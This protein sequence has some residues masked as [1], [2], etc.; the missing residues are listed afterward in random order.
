MRI[1]S[2]LLIIWL[3]IAAIA[4]GQRHYYSGSNPNCAQAGTTALTVLAVPS[5]TPA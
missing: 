3:V 2:V 5:I 4:V 1:G